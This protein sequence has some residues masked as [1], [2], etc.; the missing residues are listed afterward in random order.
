MTT[1]TMFLL[2]KGLR[3]ALGLLLL[4][5]IVSGCSGPFWQFPGGAL[6]GPETELTAANRPTEAGIMQLETNPEDPYSVNVGFLVI[7][8]NIYVDPADSRSWYQNMRAN[9]HIRLRFDGNEVVHPA[10]AIAET[11]PAVLSQFEPDRNVL[12][13]MP[14]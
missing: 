1:Q 7:D 13:L 3:P 12:R 10:I 9:P 14:R 6:P 11:D 4:G 2:S 5:L 8:G